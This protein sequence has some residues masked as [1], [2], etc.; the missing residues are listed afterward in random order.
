[1]KSSSLAWVALGLLFLF[2]ACEQGDQERP[3]RVNDLTFVTDLKAVSYDGKLHFTTERFP[4][5]TFALAWTAPGDNGDQGTAAM[6][7]LRWITEQAVAEYGLNPDDPCDRDSDHLYQMR[8]EPFPGEAG[9]PEIVN[10]IYHGL[11]RG[12]TYHFCLWTLD[13]IG[14]VSKPA[15]I[16]AQIPFLG[17]TL[18]AYADNQPGLGEVAENLS[19]FSGDGYLDVA[20]ASPARGK[21]LIY[22]GRPENEIYYTEKLMDQEQK[23]VG[24]FD[25]SLIINGDSVARFGAALASIHDLD[26]DG[27]ADL[28]VAAPETSA[29]RVYIFA[30]Q[31]KIPIDSSEAWATMDGEA[32]G[33]RLGTVL[34]DCHDLNGDG[35]ADF[36]VSAP[37]AGKVYLVMGGNVGYPIGPVPA[38]GSIAAAASAVIISTPASGFGSSIACGNDFNGDGVP[39][40]VIGAPGADNGSGQKTGAAYVF[41]GGQTGV[42]KF[43]N[44]NARNLAMSIDLT[45]AGQADMVIYGE[46]DGDKF[47]Q[48]LS[49]LGDV[50]GRTLADGTR[51]F[52]VGAPGNGTGKIYVFYGGPS[53]KLQLNTIASPQTAIASQ[54]DMTIAG[55][56]G[57]L[58]GQMVRGKADLNGDGHC[59]LAASNGLGDVR[60]YYLVPGVA[61]SALKTRVFHAAAPIDSFALLPDFDRDSLADVLLGVGGLGVGYL[62][63]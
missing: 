27:K 23:R 40:L 56:A 3:G 19:D 46:T 13:E 48:S 55:S 36:A 15:H 11:E 4:A 61:G 45:G 6:Y 62:L 54:A 59:D 50:V 43:S 9:Q 58:V 24:S 2:P 20:L 31:S 28:A 37:P 38:S 14:Q 32:P 42:N 30:N 39:D 57:E 18:R 16:K 25:P 44:L 35:Y 1:M 8:G 5:K 41:F 60:I 49:K 7:D 21:V 51:D 33:D 26:Y 29:G 63:K 22:F 47:G 34:A 52:T 12:R 17:I 10:L 53:G